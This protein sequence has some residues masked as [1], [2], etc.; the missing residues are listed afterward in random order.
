MRILFLGDIVGE[1]GRKIITKHLTNVKEKMGVDLVFANAENAASGSGLTPRLFNQLTTAGVAGVTM[2]DHIYRRSEILA[3]LAGPA[4]ICKPCNYP[5]EAPGADHVLTHAKDGTPVALI[6]VMGRTFM[7]PV[8][9]PFTAMDRVLSKIGAAVKVII[10]D[11]HAEATSD[12]QLL[13]NYLAGKV[14]AVFGTHTHVPTADARILPPGTAAITDVGMTGPY[15]SIIGRKVE[16]VLHHSR[17]FE[18][19]H[20]DVAEN[21]PRMSG[22]MVD[23]DPETGRATAVQLAHW[24]LEHIEAMAKPAEASA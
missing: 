19:I 22:G 9:C 15:E 11:V 24:T 14:S 7:R 16:N 5:A 12:K 20:F 21:D 6:S 2:G 1:P 3:L 23:I 13:A 17:T 10:V 18:P 8:D 4:A